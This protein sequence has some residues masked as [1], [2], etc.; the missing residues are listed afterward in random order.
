MPPRRLFCCADGS[1]NAANCSTYQSIPGLSTCGLLSLIG[2]MK[3]TG[4]ITSDF[5]LLFLIWL[6]CTYEYPVTSIPTHN[7]KSCFNL[8][9]KCWFKQD[10]H[11]A[12]WIQSFEATS[13]VFPVT[14]KAQSKQLPSALNVARPSVDFGN[15]LS[16][17]NVFSAV[18]P[19][20][21]EFLNFFSFFIFFF[22]FFNFK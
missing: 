18:C 6:M 2:C 19:G 1:Y 15:E 8:Y 17:G 10:W 3:Y 21:R 14:N 7:R 9:Q 4:V 13:K 5:L 12:F 11:K 16:N 20:N 22:F